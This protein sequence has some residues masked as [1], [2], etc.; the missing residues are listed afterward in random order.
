MKFSN[1]KQ[2]VNIID[3]FSNYMYNGVR[4]KV[5]NKIFDDVKNVFSGRIKVDWGDENQTV[6]YVNIKEDLDKFLT[7][8][9]NEKGEY[10]ITLSAT[11]SLWDDERNVIVS[12]N[13]IPIDDEVIKH[14]SQHYGLVAETQ[15]QDGSIT[16]L[17]FLP[18][19]GEPK[20]ED[21]TFPLTIYTV[22]IR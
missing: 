3:I 15:N 11:E 9:Y 4:N 12:N 10:L 18:N 13:N 20:E 16:N 17:I 1:N 21:E 6:E 19:E 2:V 5:I 22:T 14:I 7:H 8:T